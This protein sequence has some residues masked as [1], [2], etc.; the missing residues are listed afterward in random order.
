[1]RIV[2]PG[3]SGHLGRILAR[4][5]HSLGDEVIVLGRYPRPE[6]WQMAAWNGRDLAAWSDAI[7]GSDVVINLTGRSVDCRYTAANRREILESRVN[8]TRVVG[9]AIE[10]A[11]QPPRF[12][13]NASTATIYRHSLDKDMDES[14]ELGGS[15]PNVPSTWKFSLEVAREWEEAFFEASTPGTRKI[16]LRAAMVMSAERGG[17]FDK[18]LHLVRKGLGGRA[19]S[20][21]QFMSW[22]HEDDFVRAIDFLIGRGDIEGVVNICAPH[23]LPNAEFMAVLREAWGTPA[24]LPAPRWLLEIG[25]LIMRTESELILKSRRVVPARLLNAGFEFHFPSWVEAAQDLVG[26]WERQTRV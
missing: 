24:G 15:E 25:T 8:A 14:G 5:F 13:L 3:G 19:G 16:A 4:H 21:E 22:I 11:A 18:L 6:P 26:R 9:Q 23:P 2:L 10:Q 17:A 20:G 12:W 1:M 7:D